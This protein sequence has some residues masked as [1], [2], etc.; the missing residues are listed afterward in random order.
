M[1]DMQYFRI[2]VEGSVRE[3][4]RSAHEH[5]QHIRETHHWPSESLSTPTKELHTIHA[6]IAVVSMSTDKLA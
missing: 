3:A 2:V 5:A 1:C 6:R 4:H